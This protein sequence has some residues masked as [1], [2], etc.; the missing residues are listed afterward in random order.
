MR[1]VIQRIGV[2]VLGLA[3]LAV[4]L[5][6]VVST[7]RWNYDYQGFDVTAEQINIPS[8]ESAVLRGEHVATIHYCAACHGADLSGGYLMDEPLL[9]VVPAPNLTAG[10]GGVG[11]DN[12]AEDWV[13]AIRHGI[14]HDR[15][16]LIGMPSRV[17]YHLSD[18][19]LGDLFA[20]LKHLP[21]VD[22][23]MPPRKI[24]P[25][26]RLMLTLGKAPPSQAMIIPHDASRPKAPP[27]EVS[28][29][30]G[31]YLAQSCMGC[32][33]ANLNGGTVRDLDGNLV[34]AHNLTPGGEI[35]GWSGD[36]FIK[37]LRTGVNPAGHELNEAM[38]WPYLGQMTDEE[39]QAV[40]LYLK[41]LPALEQS[42]DRTDL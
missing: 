42:T 38:P 21:P 1:T 16:G 26:F 13:L 23:Q 32:H 9:A 30:Y 6:Y 36:D 28:V 18:N 35:G 25:L 40:W 12:S 34:V 31:G 29:A 41:S 4:L 27:Q 14:G 37:T 39:L 3:M 5:V 20:Y 24:G 7:V 11:A 17:W 2:S 15:R 10:V 22:N 19:D 8:S 33:G